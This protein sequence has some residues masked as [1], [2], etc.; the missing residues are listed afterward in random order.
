MARLVAAG[1]DELGLALE[2]SWQLLF[3]HDEE[4]AAAFV[5]VGR[6]AVAS[7]GTEGHCAVFDRFVGGFVVEFVLAPMAGKLVVAV[8]DSF[9]VGDIDTAEH[10]A[11]FAGSIGILRQFAQ[12]IGTTTNHIDP[13]MDC[14]LIAFGKLGSS[15]LVVSMESSPIS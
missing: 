13:T 3:Y 1:N 8:L 5:I 15:R 11:E 9:A 10:R 12:S 14:T 4:I 6:K 7:F 2:S